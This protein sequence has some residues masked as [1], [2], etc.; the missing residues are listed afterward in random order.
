MNVVREFVVRDEGPA[1]GQHPAGDGVPQICDP[2][3][4]IADGGR[5]RTLRRTWLDTFEWRLFR[6]GLNLECTAGRGTSELTL[7]GR[8]GERVATEV[9][10]RTR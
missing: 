5:P 9:A 2:R 1:G 8:D 7:T 6:A 10:G 3:F 4:S